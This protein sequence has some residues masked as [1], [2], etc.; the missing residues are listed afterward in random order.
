M[1]HSSEP[2]FIIAGEVSGDIFAADLMSQI[3]KIKPST[4]IGFG[5][6]HM[7][8]E[9]FTCLTED[10]SL[11]SSIGLLE[12]TR[13]L[14]KHIGM[15]N[16]IIPTIKKNNIKKV[17]L[18]DHE[19]FCI[20]AAKKIRKY[21]KNNIEIY[22]FIPPRVSMWG[23]KSAPVTAHL[24]DALFCYMKPDQ[25][26]YLKYNTNSFYFG[27][28]LAKK[29]KTFV[30]NPHFFNKHGLNPNKEYM[31]LMPG[32]RKQEIDN[33]LP[34]FLKAAEKIHDK[35]RSEF[36]MTVAHDGLKDKILKKINKTNIADKIHIINE[37]S[38]EIMSHVTIGLV[39]A[40]T[41]T[42]EAV[43]MK[44]YP[45]IAYKLSNFTFEMLRKSENLPDDTLIGLPNVLLQKRIFP[46]LLQEEVN[47]E[48]IVE[49]ITSIKSMNPESFE[50]LMNKIFNELSDQLGDTDSIK[51]VAEYIMTKKVD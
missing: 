28:P 24:C 31:A 47:A 41:I 22:F 35:Y 13:F 20:I 34:V 21:F 42:I 1:T 10:N 32:S 43:M 36:L 17:I 14:S 7:Q 3:N 19:V 49:E 48:R 5:G 44:M 11:F 30:P 18:V 33:L 46:E 27:N 39:S 37:S 51:K 40:G 38:L 26:I 16:K 15:L 50:Y 8:K 23:A 29:L 6:V 25:D 12:S 2:I 4:F 9:N 45:I